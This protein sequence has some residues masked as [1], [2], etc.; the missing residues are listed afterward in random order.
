MNLIKTILAVLL[1]AGSMA[2]HHHPRRSQ[3]FNPFGMTSEFN[4]LFDLPKRGNHMG[5]Q[6]KEME[7]MFEDFA[8][9][10]TQV[11]E[12]Q[13]KIEIVDLPV[14]AVAPVQGNSNNLFFIW[15][16]SRF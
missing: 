4:K 12:P 8:Q 15:S 10:T 2:R 16:Y 6:M 3:R 1:V 7:K 9:I 5:Q 13:L 11:Q 14:A